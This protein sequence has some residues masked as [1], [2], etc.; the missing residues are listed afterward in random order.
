M[1]TPMIKIVGMIGQNKLFGI[2]DDAVENAELDWIIPASSLLD[3]VIVRHSSTSEIRTHYYT[4]K[5]YDGS[6]ITIRTKHRAQAISES[7]SAYIIQDRSGEG[8]RT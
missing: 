2:S 8:S 5:K 7:S 4:V 1:S 3:A 6:I